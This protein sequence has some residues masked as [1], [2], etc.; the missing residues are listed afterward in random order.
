MGRTVNV[1]KLINKQFVLV[2]LIMLV[3]LLLVDRNV[4]LVQNVHSMKPVL[5]KNASIL[6][7]DVVVVMPTVKSTII[8]QFAHVYQVIQEMRFLLAQNYHVSEIFVTICET[9][10]I[11]TARVLNLSHCMITL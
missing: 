6:A 9:I 5:A 1:A 2:Y 11:S 10:H 4:L 3:L 7:R 8:A